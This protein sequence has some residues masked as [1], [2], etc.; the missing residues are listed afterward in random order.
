MLNIICSVYFSYVNH[1]IT[2]PSASRTTFENEINLNLDIS[3]IESFLWKRLFLNNVDRFI[4]TKL[5]RIKVDGT[6]KNKKKTENVS[7]ACIND[8][9]R[10]RSICSTF[11][12]S[13]NGLYHSYGVFVVVVS[14]PR[15]RVVMCSAV[16][17]SRGKRGHIIV[18]YIPDKRPF[19]SK[20]F[21]LY[22]WHDKDAWS[23]WSS[24]ATFTCCRSF[25]RLY[26]KKHRENHRMLNK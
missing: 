15:Y 7:S 19:F 1:W 6:I 12:F 26:R 9:I 13:I 3:S 23:Y 21:R 8:M 14:S 16:S 10:K 24:H 22:H 5:Y 4:T 25:T 20:I 11:D 2:Q 18:M 17:M